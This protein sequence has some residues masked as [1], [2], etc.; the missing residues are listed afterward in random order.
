MIIQSTVRMS[1]TVLS[2]V[3]SA[4]NVNHR[5]AQRI[6]SNVRLVPGE[7]D[8]RVYTCICYLMSHDQLQSNIRPSPG[9]RFSAARSV[10]LSDRTPFP[11]VRRFRSVGI[12]HR[13]IAG[14]DSAGWAA[15][16]ARQPRGR[17]TRTCGTHVRRLH[18]ADLSCAA[19]KELAS[20]SI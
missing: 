4:L 12:G 3:R 18:L 9:T 10:I 6:S 1:T 13:A 7:V 2:C 14:R 19:G 11:R 8:S 16:A 15:P 5:A 17:P 20:S